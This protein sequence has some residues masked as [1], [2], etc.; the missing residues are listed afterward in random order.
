MDAPRHLFKDYGSND[1][2][3]LFADSGDNALLHYSWTTTGTGSTYFMLNPS[4]SVLLI[5]DPS[6]T[7]NYGD[8][9][10]FLV[11]VRDN[12]TP[13]LSGT[14]TLDLIYRVTSEFQVS[15]LNF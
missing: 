4:G 13:A 12:G 10:R 1:L 11:T 7:V 14:T 3:Y 8:R 9:F 6:T 2:L 15:Q 5:K